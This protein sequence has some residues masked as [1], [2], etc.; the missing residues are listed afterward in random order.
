MQVSVFDPQA[1]KEEVCM[2][3]AFTFQDLAELKNSVL[4]Q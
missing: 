1:D 3:T 2:S 4:K